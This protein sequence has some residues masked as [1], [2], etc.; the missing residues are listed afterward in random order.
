MLEVIRA[1]PPVESGSGAWGS[2]LVDRIDNQIHVFFHKLC[3]ELIGGLALAAFGVAAEKKG[4]SGLRVGVLRFAGW[5]GCG[6]WADAGGAVCGRCVLCCAARLVRRLLRRGP[7]APE[8]RL[9]EH[10]RFRSSSL[11]DRRARQTVRASAGGKG[12]S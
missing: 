8:G 12:G 4:E 6:F 3:A 10:V 9:R 1:F 7:S 2:A 11:P 5:W